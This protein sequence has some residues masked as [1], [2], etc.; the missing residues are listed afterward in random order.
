MFREYGGQAA[1]QSGIDMLGC[2]RSRRNGPGPL[3][4]NARFF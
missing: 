3:D 2:A 1:R 4:I